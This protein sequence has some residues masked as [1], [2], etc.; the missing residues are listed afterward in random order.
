MSNDTQSIFISYAWGGEREEIV[1][2]IDKSLQERGVKITRD[3]RDLG[4][5]GSIKEFME[6]I[7]KGNCII[8]VI[9]DKYLRSPI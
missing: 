6:R 8:V 2:Q 5:K 9:S 4:Y 7:G 3:K 1:N